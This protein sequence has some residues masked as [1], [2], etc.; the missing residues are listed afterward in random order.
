MTSLGAP[1]RRW[2]P[3]TRPQSDAAGPGGD[4]H[5]AGQVEAG[6]RARGLSGSRPWSRTA[7][8]SPIGTLIQKIQ[9]QFR[10]WT[11]A[12]PTSGPPATASPP[13]PPQMPMIDPRRAGGKALVRIVRLSGVTS[14]RAKALDRPAAIRQPAV[15]ASAQAADATV[16][17]SRP[18]T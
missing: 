6:T 13:I 2:P 4:Q 7:A 11:T 8:A 14:G 18:A 12:P 10:P 1:A 16:N 9:C 3:R 15:G 17:S 5:H